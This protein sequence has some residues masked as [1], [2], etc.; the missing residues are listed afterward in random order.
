MILSIVNLI[1]TSNQFKNSYHKIDDELRNFNDARVQSEYKIQKFYQSNTKRPRTPETGVGNNNA[2]GRKD[3]SAK[4]PDFFQD[5]DAIK[6]K[7]FSKSFA[8]T[9][10]KPRKFLLNISYSGINKEDF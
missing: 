6:K 10:I 3:K 5:Y 1:D 2:T 4:R 7:N 8:T 9:N